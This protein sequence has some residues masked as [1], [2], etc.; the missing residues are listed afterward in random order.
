MPANLGLGEHAMASGGLH[1][2]LPS[3]GSMGNLQAMQVGAA[4]LRSRN[5]ASGVCIGAGDPLA[6]PGLHHLQPTSPASSYPTSPPRH[7]RLSPQAGIPLPGMPHGLM[8]SSGELQSMHMMGGAAMM[9]AAAHAAHSGSGSPGGP[10]GGHVKLGRGVVD[11]A[12]YQHK[13]FI[14]QIPFEVRGDGSLQQ[15]ARLGN[16]PG[17]ASHCSAAPLATPSCAA[18]HRLAPNLAPCAL[19]LPPQAIE[20]DL[21]ALFAPVGDI[22]ELAILRSQGRSK[23]CAFLTYASRQQVR[24]A[25]GLCQLGHCERGADGQAGWCCPQTAPRVT[26]L[27]TTRPACHLT[28]LSALPSPSPPPQAQTA[29]QAFN[30]RQVGPTKRLVVKFADQK[31]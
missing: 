4:G 24:G 28:C 11:P 8:G 5:A 15:V 20:Q 30:G 18:R 22:L 29:I 1:H 12:A 26:V 6:Q 7:P 14:G 13:L 25:A 16:A 17:S 2:G 27:R 10:R 23:G 9:M 3:S 21:W 31:A 19:P